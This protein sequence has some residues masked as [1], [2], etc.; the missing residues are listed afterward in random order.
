MEKSSTE[1]YVGMDV[2][3]D[4]IDIAVAEAGRGG[5]IRHVGSIGGDVAAVDR[6][7]RK[8][9]S[10]GRRVHVVYEAGP[11][12]Y[13]LYRHLKSKGI[14]VEVVAPSSIPKRPGDRIK[15]DR[16]DA[17]MLARL[18]RSGDLTAVVVPDESDEAVRDLMRAREDAVRAQRTARQQL[19]ALLLRNGIRY[20]GK[21]G[22]GPA[23]VRWLASL[24][25][26]DAAR[27]FA[28]QEYVNAVESATARLGRIEGAIREQV[29]TWRFS[30]VVEALQALRGI[31]LV[32][33]ASLVAEI[34]AIER[35]SHP[36]QL[37]AY[38]GL[39]PSEHSSGDKR[40]Q[41]RITKAGNGHAR[42][43]LVEVAW[44]Y[45]YPARVAPILQ[46][47]WDKV[48]QAVRDIAWKAQVR[49]CGRFRR[50]A[51]RKVP[52]N[53]IVIAVARELAGFIWAIAQVQAPRPPGSAPSGAPAG[54]LQP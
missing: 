17:M 11:C 7:L 28:F 18:S 50:L 8:L 51:A 5:E 54:A 34:G 43:M 25:L 31:Q 32:A 45:R 53:K 13:V 23:H 46:K 9:Q 22:W 48:S 41:G 35:F 21:S 52:H 40:R 12:G 27:Q 39:V 10:G 49:L 19:K 38:L 47:R 1:L 15:T 44:L 2:H 6:A 33:A 29:T 20:A 3:K 26:A 42:R 36:R 37:M 14:E 30:P 24:K 16:R 4:T